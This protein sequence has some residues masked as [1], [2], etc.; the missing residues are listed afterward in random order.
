MAERAVIPPQS[1]NNRFAR[2]SQTSLTD[3][4]QQF[5][6]D[7]ALAILQLRHQPGTELTSPAQTRHYLQ[8]LLGPRQHEV[9]GCVYLDS[10]H[11]VIEAVE[12]FQGTIDRSVVYP[13][14]VVQKA[15]SV[16]AAA[17]VFY[18]NHPS[19]VAEP[20]AEDRAMTKKLSDTLELV[21]I[22][23]LDHFVVS[24]SGSVSFAESGW[25]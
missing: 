25:L 2:L 7:W 16:N 8:L 3:C 10:Q 20:S 1:T 13:R 17:V 18:H 9:F 15:L 4:E 19:G 14:V 23:V 22:R 21:D 5:L 11:R 6:L 24:T 12:M